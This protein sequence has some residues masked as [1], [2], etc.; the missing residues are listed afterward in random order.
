M[1]LDIKS[2]II[3]T[4]DPYNNITKSPFYRVY[5]KLRTFMNLKNLENFFIDFDR[6]TFQKYAKIIHSD[7]SDA[8]EKGDQYIISRS[9]NPTMIEV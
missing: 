8:L 7:I 4:K 6:H 2:R 9:L 1:L 3:L 5:N